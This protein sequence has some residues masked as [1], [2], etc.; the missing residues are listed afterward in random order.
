MNI[1]KTLRWDEIQRTRDCDKGIGEIS[2]LDLLKA[3]G[4]VETYLEYEPT[5]ISLEVTS[6]TVGIVM[7]IETK[8][9][10]A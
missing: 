6:E 3:F 7:L 2:I 8:E 1:S 9:S 10:A 5:C 4:L